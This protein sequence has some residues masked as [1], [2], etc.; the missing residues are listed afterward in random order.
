[1]LY[2]TKKHLAAKVIYNHEK[3]WHISNFWLPLRKQKNFAQ[4]NPSTKMKNTRQDK[5]V[6]NKGHYYF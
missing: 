1:M 5:A 4:S 6:K 3:I 2:N